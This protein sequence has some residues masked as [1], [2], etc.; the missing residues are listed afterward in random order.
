MSIST[1][2]SG[3]T[4]AYLSIEK[5][6]PLIVIKEWG[7]EMETVDVSYALFYPYNYGKW[8]C[9][10]I[11]MGDN[12]CL[13]KWAMFGNH[14]IDWEHAEVRFQKGKPVKAFLPCHAWGAEYEFNETTR[15][16]NFVKGEDGPGHYKIEYAPTIQLYQDTNHIEVFSA[17]GSHGTWGSE[18]TIC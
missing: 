17:N 16:F 18:G 9:V 10:G 13:G 4:L 7:D 11:E 5:V 6:Q 8:V 12:K 15:Q 1:S 2:S 14:L 3:I